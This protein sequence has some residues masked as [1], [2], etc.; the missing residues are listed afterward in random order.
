MKNRIIDYIEQEK[1]QKEQICRRLSLYQEKLD[2]E[3][4][5]DWTGEE[6]LEICQYLNINPYDFYEEIN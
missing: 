6:L 5:V 3:S 4:T 1:M 2:K